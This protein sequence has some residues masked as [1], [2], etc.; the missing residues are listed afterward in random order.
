M[1]ITAIAIPIMPNHTALF[2]KSKELEEKEIL[3][4]KL[5]SRWQELEE[6]V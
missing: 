5:Y 6:K 4:E 1:V 3:L 2:E